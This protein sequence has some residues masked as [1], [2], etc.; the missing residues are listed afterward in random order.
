[1]EEPAVGGHRATEG[2]HNEVA[3]HEVAAW[4][5][6]PA[7]VTLHVGLGCE[8]LLERIHRVARLSLL[9]PTHN[10]I[11]N[12]EQHEHA[13]VYQ[14]LCRSFGALEALGDLLNADGQLDDDTH[15]DEQRHRRDEGQQEQYQLP[16]ARQ[17]ARAQQVR[18]MGSEE[19]ARSR[20]A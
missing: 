2:E 14:V 9:M 4:D 15:P 11:H 18:L 19:I 3:G 1:M 17:G 12:L 5:D 10:G 6:L 8:A 13:K 20:G 16:A 7:A